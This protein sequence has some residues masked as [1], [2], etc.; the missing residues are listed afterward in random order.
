[1]SEST[2]IVQLFVGLLLSAAG[3]HASCPIELSPP[4]VVV[5]YGDPVSINCSTSETLFEGIGWEATE[6]A[7]VLQNV[8]HLTWTVDRLT[9][10]Y[11]SPS[12]YFNPLENSPIDQCFI[13]PEV[14]LY[15]FPEAITIS[16]NSAFKGVLKEM[17]E[18]NFT[19]DIPNI[20]PV[21]SLTV[22]W[23][24][25]DDLLRTETF[26]NPSKERVNQTS[27]LGFKATRQDSGV[28]FRCEAHMDLGHEEL[29]FNVSSQDYHIKVH[30]GPEVQCSGNEFLE[31]ETLEKKCPVAGNPTPFVKWLKDGQPADPTLPL[32]REN[33]GQYIIEAEGSSHTRKELQVLVLCECL[34][35]MDQS[36]YVQKLTLHWS[37]LPTISPVLLRAFLNLRSSG[38][39]MARRWIFSETLTRR[40]AGQ[41]IITA[42]N[43]HSSVNLSVDITVLYPPSQIV[44]LV[45]SEV[46]VGSTVWLKCSSTGNPR[47]KYFWDYYRTDNVMEDNDDGVS[48]LLIH[49]VTAFNMG[50]YTCHAWNDMGNVSETARVTVKGAK[51]E[52]PIE[53]TPDRMVIEYQ[54]RSQNATCKAISNLSGNVKEIYWQDKQGIKTSTSWSA[55]T[56]KDWDP[57]PVCT[58]TFEGIGSC[59]KRLNF[60]LYK[61]PDSVSIRPVNHTGPM[62]E[63]K[64]YQLLCEVQN[65]APVQYLTLRWYRGQT[66][67]YNHSFADLTSTSPVQVSSILLVTPTKAENGAQYRCVAELELGPEGPKPPPTVT[68]E[69]LNASVYFPPA[70]LNP[71]PEVLDLIEG[72]E[73][74]LNCTATGNPAPVYS[75]QSS[76]PIP[77]RMEDEAVLTSSSLIPGT[78]T[79]TA[80]NTLE[81]R[82]KQ[83][84]I[85]AATKG[86]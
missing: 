37:M 20:A 33:A 39:K 64:E 83:F 13:I 76:H 36:C 16:S 63:G 75:W 40:Q 43:K 67:V 62:V 71:E 4:S 52:C 57:R 68:S 55:D 47:P 1:M 60:T 72:A 78:Y 46:D 25:G 42:S 15:T 19:C 24:K 22:R 35:Q 80:S 81:K 38:T 14:V 84:I 9:D 28:T 41:Y 56:Y 86:A 21:Q 69:P 29:Q 2:S 34:I 7:K 17:E 50:L 77:E 49:N 65:I 61:T 6:G 26:K 53:I 23:Y 66:E 27:I 11:I 85:K 48:R 59:Q 31:G 70:F 79:C 8:T 51:Q 10:W 73:I 45:D 18:Y 32:T 44:E 58:A 74:T 12:C 5:K 54:G 82:S 3:A 30:F